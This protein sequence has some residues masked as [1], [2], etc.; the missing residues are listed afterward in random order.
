MAYTYTDRQE[1]DFANI[2]LAGPC[3]QRCP[4]CIGQQLPSELSQSNLSRFPPR[5]LDLFAA[6]LRRHRV[7]QIVLTGTNTDP[8]LYQHEARLIRWLRERLPRAQLSLHTN[9]QL[10][11]AKMEVFNLYNRVTLSFPS[12][13]PGTFCRMAGTR[14]MPDLPA[15]LQA[16]R[17]P[18]KISCVLDEPNAGQVDEF[19]TRCHQLGIRRLVFRQLYGD[20]HRRSVPPYLKPVALYRH[21]PVYDYDGMQVTYWSFGGTTSTALNLFSD[22]SISTQYLLSKHALSQ[23]TGSTRNPTWRRQR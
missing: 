12:F 9:G 18:V 19:L 5:N 1:Y 7:R 3:N 2:L 14:H 15:I 4:Y 21:N 6:M 17:I 8:Q 13:D 20:T 11:L 16:A 23:S 10:A 22:G